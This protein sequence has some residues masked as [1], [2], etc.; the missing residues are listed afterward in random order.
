MST[1]WVSGNLCICEDLRFCEKN[2]ENAFP[3]KIEKQMVPSE[4]APQELSNEWSCHLGFDNLRFFG[5]F[6]CPAII[7]EVTIP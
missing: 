5:K 2:S 7:T 3:P 1:S 6:L 4:S